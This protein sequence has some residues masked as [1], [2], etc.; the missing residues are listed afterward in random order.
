[1]EDSHPTPA[2][3]DFPPLP[4]KKSTKHLS[5]ITLV[6]LCLLLVSAAAYFVLTRNQIKPPEN[7]T[8]SQEDLSSCLEIQ[9]EHTH[10]IASGG[11]AGPNFGMPAPEYKVNP[12]EGKAA[13]TTNIEEMKVLVGSKDPVVLISLAG[14][15]NLP[16]EI[17][18]QL[19]KDKQLP[20]GWNGIG[21]TLFSYSLSPQDALVRQLMSNEGLDHS[22]VENVVDRYISHDPEIY[23]DYISLLIQNLVDFKPNS[24]GFAQLGKIA[25]LNDISFNREISKI[26]NLDPDTV[27]YLF[28]NIDYSLDESNVSYYDPKSPSFHN[29]PSP[30]FEVHSNLLRSQTGIPGELILQHLRETRDYPRIEISQ[31]NFAQIAEEVLS[32]ETRDYFFASTVVNNGVNQ[33][34][35]AYVFNILFHGIALNEKV[36]VEHLQLLIDLYADSEIKRILKEERLDFIPTMEKIDHTLQSRYP[37][38]HNFEVSALR[39]ALMGAQKNL[40]TRASGTNRNSP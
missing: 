15:P 11:D 3:S 25:R 23:Y 2:E 18:W 26:A 40:N 38:W 17:Q 39:N 7:R 6:A 36:S 19:F 14:N 12:C 9:K 29:N 10:Q 33:G 16:Q 1:M 28:R 13:N 30:N 24:V 8:S 21:L 32:S 20:P 35:Y 4:E 37:T 27:L 22:I 31:E 34:R 5:R